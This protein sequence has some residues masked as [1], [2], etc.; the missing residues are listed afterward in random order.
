MPVTTKVI[1]YYIDYC[2]KSSREEKAYSKC[3]LKRGK[4]I[5]MKQE[6][7]SHKL[8]YLEMK[9]KHCKKLAINE[10]DCAK[11]LKVGGAKVIEQYIK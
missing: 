2:L 10:A 8:M 7:L 9:M 1:N 11:D 5:E 3:I 6:E 4:H